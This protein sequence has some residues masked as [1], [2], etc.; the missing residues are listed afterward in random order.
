MT[1]NKAYC[2]IHCVPHTRLHPELTHI[3]AFA[4]RIYIL[5]CYWPRVNL[6][7][8]LVSFTLY[9]QERRVT[10]ELTKLVLFTPITVVPL[11]SESINDTVCV[12]DCMQIQAQ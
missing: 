10:F 12:V 9:L 4:N 2:A 8:G 7:V 3:S 6:L 5:V 11:I 1:A